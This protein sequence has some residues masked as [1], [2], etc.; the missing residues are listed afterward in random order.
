[1]RQT[2]QRKTHNIS[3][4]LKT[5]DLQLDDE[6]NL[7]KQFH[8]FNRIMIFFILINRRQLILFHSHQF[9]DVICCAFT[10]LKQHLQKCAT[11]TAAG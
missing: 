6:L 9:N 7:S 4:T 10:K 2:F 8:F 5:K 11:K 3:K 1:M